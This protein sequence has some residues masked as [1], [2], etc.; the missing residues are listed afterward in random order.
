MNRLIFLIFLLFFIFLFL[1]NTYLEDFSASAGIDAYWR[2]SVKFLPTQNQYLGKDVFFT[3]G[4]LSPYIL[5]A[6][7]ASSDLI[8]ALIPSL[9]K[10]FLFFII[11]YLIYRLSRFNAKSLLFLLPLVPLL[12][13]GSYFFTFIDAVI[14]IILLLVIV[15][16]KQLKKMPMQARLPSR[17]ILPSRLPHQTT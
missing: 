4:P 6:P 8:F 2:Y 1:S 7:I 12:I 16:I 11:F 13:D 3:Y 9:F 14:Y 5:P 17:L 10:I 15:N